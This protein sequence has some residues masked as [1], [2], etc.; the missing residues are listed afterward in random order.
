MVT[1]TY[2][3]FMGAM[4][5]GLVLLIWVSTSFENRTRMKNCAAC[6]EGTVLFTSRDEYLCGIHYDR[7]RRITLLEMKMDEWETD[8]GGW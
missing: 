6:R 4:I 7:R 8:N 5:L 2:L 3:L 1:V